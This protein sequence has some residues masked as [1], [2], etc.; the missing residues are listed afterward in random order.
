MFYRFCRSLFRFFF[1][2]FCGWKVEGLDNF[3]Q[4]GPVLVIANHTSY[5]DP[6]VVGSALGRKVH[7]MAKSELFSYPVLGFV[8]EKMGTFPVSRDRVDLSSLK[9]ALAL[10]DEGNVVCIFPEGTRS[11]T[12]KILPPLP[13]AAFLARKAG[14][15]VCPVALQRR[16]RMFGNNLF[17]YFHV[18]VGSTFYVK[19]TGK[20]D[21]Q[22]DADIMMSKIQELI[23][24]SI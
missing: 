15:P 2:V 8:I 1:T 11:K 23:D 17:P 14:T 19:K 7:F 5:W 22:A 13:G 4:K 16:Q 9:R 21:F 3:P 6:I 24:N 10:L 20:R 12:G 18:R